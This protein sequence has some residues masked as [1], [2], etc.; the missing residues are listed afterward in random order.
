MSDKWSVQQ[1]YKKMLRRHGNL[2]T[3]N[4]NGNYSTNGKWTNTP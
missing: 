3:G 2:F 4:K 1:L